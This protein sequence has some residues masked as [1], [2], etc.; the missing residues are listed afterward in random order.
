MKPV[1]SGRRNTLNLSLVQSFS[2]NQRDRKLLKKVGQ[3]YLQY[4]GIVDVEDLFKA[5]GATTEVEIGDHALSYVHYY[6]LYLATIGAVEAAR[7]AKRDRLTYREFAV[8]YGEEVYGELSVE[9]SIVVYPMRL[10]AY[11]S[12]AEGYNAPEYS[13]LGYLL[14]EIF[15]IVKEKRDEMKVTPPEIKYF[16]FFRDFD[17]KFSELEKV[18]EEFPEGYYRP[19]VYTDPE[20]LTKAFKSLFLAERVEQLR[21]GVKE[22]KER[23]TEVRRD[24]IKYMM[25]K[26]YELYTFYLIANYLESIGYEIKKEGDSKYIAVKG[27]KRLTLL[28]NA[29]LTNSSLVRVDEKEGEDAINQFRGRPDVSLLNERPIIFE[30]KYSSKASYVTAGRFKIMAYTYEY[31]PLTAVL[32]YPGLKEG[33]DFDSE[34]EATRDLDSLAKKEGGV[35]NFEFNRHTLYMLIL[36]PLDNDDINIERIGKILRNY[37]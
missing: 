15:R 31:D 27:D 16:D 24:L 22:K 30:C 34:D 37:V 8:E 18:K 29:P 26:L 35:L 2:V 20:W 1:G 36:N 4:K 21:V 25:W 32:I 14:R 28:F 12:F 17:E 23:K 5:L 19:P 3:Y 7:E 13:V 6:L 9:R 11:Y 33:E 10:Y